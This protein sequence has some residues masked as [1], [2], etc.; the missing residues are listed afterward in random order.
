MYIATRVADVKILDS[1][2]DADGYQSIMA[3][4][5]IEF[6]TISKASAIGCTIFEGHRWLHHI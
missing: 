3:Y 5:M 2:F 6:V 4:P 1:T